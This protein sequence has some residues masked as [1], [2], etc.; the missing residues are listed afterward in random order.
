MAE[1]KPLIICVINEDWFFRSHFLPWGMAAR[2]AGYDVVV[3]ATRG[4][5][6]AIIEA[7]GI[8]VIASRASRGGVLPRGLWGAARQLA[9]L[10]HGRPTVLIHAFGLHG[11]AIAALA[12]RLFRLAPP[13]TVSVTGLGFLA[14]EQHGLKRLAVAVLRR[15]VPALL[16]GPRTIWLTENPRDGEFLRLDRARDEGRIAE[17]GGAGV[18]TD[19]FTPAPLPPAPPLRLILVARMIRSKGVDLAVEAVSLARQRGMDVTLTLVGGSDP[20]NPRALSQADLAAFSARE[21]IDLLG[22]R[23]DIAALL[24][25]H[26][27]FILPSRGGEGLPKAL[28]EAAAA[29]RPAIVSNVPGCA[30]FVRD[31]KTG[32]VASL[33]AEALADAIARLVA[34]DLAALG[35]AARERCLAVSS[36]ARVSARVVDSYR[37]L[38]SAGDR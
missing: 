22:P 32:F 7:A 24:A 34:A 6:A 5:E 14:A 37:H 19:A 36:S 25:A 11:M 35:G 1:A 28:L 21:G 26:H 8:P 13:L 23:R 17:L 9:G 16:D 18:D 38:L 29:G 15:G 20:G 2:A 27:A 12:R 3:L 31:G 30:D 10:V 33:S 4:A